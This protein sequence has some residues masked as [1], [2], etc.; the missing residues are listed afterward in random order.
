MMGYQKVKEF[1]RYVEPFDTIPDRDGSTDTLQQHIRRAM[2]F[3]ALK[4]N[5]VYRAMLHGRLSVRVS[6]K[7]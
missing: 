3:R 1:R 5:I 4:T 7:T 2:R 6:A